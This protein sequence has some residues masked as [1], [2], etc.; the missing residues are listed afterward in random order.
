VILHKTAMNALILLAIVLCVFVMGYRFYSKFLVLG[1][2]QPRTD[3]AAP[4]HL[5]AADS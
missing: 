4:A 5:R 2:F 1:M 3:V